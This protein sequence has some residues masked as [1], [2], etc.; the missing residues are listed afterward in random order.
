MD[1][2][3]PG[4]KGGAMEGA[5]EGSDEEGVQK[6]MANGFAPAV[7][8]GPHGAGD[9]DSGHRSAPPRPLL[10]TRHSKLHEADMVR[11]EDLKDEKMK[12]ETLCP[13]I[14]FF[15]LSQ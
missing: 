10:D 3:S 2:A 13:Y 5:V 1:G 15:C 7:G 8:G 4:K 9:S 6:S 14:L 11:A 12:S